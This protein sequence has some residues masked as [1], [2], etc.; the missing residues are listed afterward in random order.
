MAVD[1]WPYQFSTATTVPP[2]N[3]DVRI[4]TAAPASA[5]KLW[6]AALNNDN[7]DVWIGLM[8]VPVGG[9]IYI[10]NI[11]D[12]KRA[13]RYSVTGPPLDKGTY[14]E[15]PVGYVGATSLPVLRPAAVAVVTS[16]KGQY[17]PVLA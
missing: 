2:I 15:I 13:V 16:D 7:T 9:L 11:D 4:N 1:N 3:G 17:P 12:H 8:S 6:I 5:T 14:V 10:Q